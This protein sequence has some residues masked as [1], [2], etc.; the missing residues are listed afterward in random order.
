MC[1]M[2]FTLHYRGELKSASR[3]NAQLENK[4]KIRAHFHKQLNELWKYP[5]LKDHGHLLSG[6]G[7]I[8]KK[9]G[10]FNFAPLVSK[11]I[12]LLAEMNIL[13][14]RPSR[15]GNIISAGGDID[16][17]LKTLFDALSMP[18]GDNNLPKDS[19]PDRGQDP[20]YC[21]V[22]D[23]GLISQVTVDTDRILEPIIDPQEVILL[24]K[25]TT[26]KIRGLIATGGL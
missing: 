24:I 23:D 5:P 9:V 1:K 4:H 2:E 13:M 8:I 25:V 7:S 11:S 12:Y 21:V 17:R 19:Q 22:E 6:D 20:F 15:K 10:S 3:N 26:R 18:P 14:L 16:N